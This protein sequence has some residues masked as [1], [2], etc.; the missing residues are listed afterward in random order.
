LAWRIHVEASGATVTLEGSVRSWTE[1]Q[2]AERAAR[3]ARG[4]AVVANR[5]MIVP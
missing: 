1:T 3:T 2:E 4:V 5:I